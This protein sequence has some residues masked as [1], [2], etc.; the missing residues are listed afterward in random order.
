MFCF[1]C[2]ETAQGKGCTIKGVCGKPAD[3]ANLQDLLIFLLKGISHKAVKMRETGKEVPVAVNRFIIESLFMTITN[4]NFDKERFVERIKEAIA[5]RDGLKVECVACSECDCLSWSA[6][7]VEQMEQKA[8]QV[9]VLQ[10]ENEDIRSL[11]G[12]ITYGLKIGR[13]HV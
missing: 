10:T 4:A 7:T 9:G 13:A 1:Q 6:D 12:L 11:R 5:L 2:Q 3:V 8:A